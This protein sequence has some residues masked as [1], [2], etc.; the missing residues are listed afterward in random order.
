M[1][2]KLPPGPPLVFFRE[3]LDPRTPDAI[4]TVV[5]HIQNA[6]QVSFK[7]GQTG[8]ALTELENAAMIL[9][10]E[11]MGSPAPCVTLS[12]DDLVPYDREVWDKE[13]RK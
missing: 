1:T 3:L 4:N 9:V 11:I 13:R 7:N 6:R 10:G 12:A 8:H 5:A 2:K